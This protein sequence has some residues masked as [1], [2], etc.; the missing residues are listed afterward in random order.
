MNPQRPRIAA[1]ITCALTALVATPAHPATRTVAIT[2]QLIP[3][4]PGG[5][6][7]KDFDRPDLLAINNSGHVAFYATYTL[8]I[9][10]DV[11]SIWAGHPDDLSLLGYVAGDAPDTPSLTFFDQF[12]DL[13]L[14]N[15]GH[16]AYRASLFGSSVT[17]DDDLGI[18]SN[19]A[20]GPTQLIA[21]KG[22]TA[23]GSFS[24]PF[25][26][27]GTPF[28]NDAGQLAFKGTLD[29]G[30]TDDNEGI[31]LGDPADIDRI[32]LEGQPAPDLPAGGDYGNQLN[33]RAINPSG[34][35]TISNALQSGTGD[36]TIFNNA[37]QWAG[38]PDELMLFL[39]A[40]TPAPDIPG[41]LNFENTSG[42]A[43]INA[44]GHIAFR[45]GIECFC[46]D[47]QAIWVGPPEDLKVAARIA[48]PA[49]DAPLGARFEFFNSLPLLASNGHLAF[50]ATLEEGRGGVTAADDTVL[51]LGPP[52]DL[53]IAARKGDQA[54]GAPPGTNFDSFFETAIN[55]NG[56]AVIMNRVLGANQGIYLAD[57]H[58]VIPVALS[59]GTLASQ[60]IDNIE[61]RD[62]FTFSGDA[63]GKPRVINDRGQVVFYADFTSGDSGVFLFTPDLHYRNDSSGQWDDHN[64]WTVGIQPSDIHNV[65]IDTDVPLTVHGPTETTTLN[66]LTIGGGT[67]NATL[68]LQGSAIYTPTNVQ[69]TSNGTLT[70]N[71]FID[72][73]VNNDGTVLLDG[74]LA[75]DGNLNNNATL[76]GHGTLDA[77][78]LNNSTALLRVDAGQS[79]TITGFANTN[80]GRINLLGGTLAFTQN[81]INRDP[82]GL[83]TGTGHIHT[84]TGLT[85]RNDI[86]LSGPSTIA[87]DVVNDPGALILSTGGG[88]LTFLDDVNNEGD[89]QTSPGSFTVFLGTYAGRGKLLGAGTVNMQGDFTPGT[90]PGITEIAGDLVFGPFATFKAETLATNTAP[91]AG[92]DHDQIN[93]ANQLTLNG[94]LDVTAL[95][96]TGP[97]E[98]TTLGNEYVVIIYG[99][100]TPD[101]FFHTITGTLIDTGFA[102]APL[103]D[104]ATN[105]FI[106][107]ASVPGDLNFDNK[108]SVADLSTF[109]L[110]FNTTPGLYVEATNENSWELGDFNTDGAITVS[111]LSLLA[112]NFGFDA[113]AT[114]D[115]I[116][117]IGLSL[118]EIA[119]IA[120]I[121]PAAIPEPATV[122]TAVIC[123][124]GLATRR[125]R[126]CVTYKNI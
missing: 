112:L 119:A 31:W 67:A 26:F 122:L 28:L 94:T 115:P 109:A 92:I 118:V 88:P 48:H 25:E 18:W 89:I 90:S 14:N 113:T 41:D 91:V 84:A 53:K 22:D 12:L 20:G 49:P 43:T 111:D 95:P 107:R 116:P 105:Q 121:D 30:S 70:G 64:N 125:P 10:V 60:T 1:A 93:I 86:A 24:D 27:L 66:S 72:R 102:L 29:T 126:H 19:A 57:Q 39:R 69:I 123:T 42:S 106:L 79:I 13:N 85:N 9:G 82:S 78:L 37:A 15:A 5:A 74:N 35:I 114:L 59:G 6:V 124:G 54:P 80:T 108:V 55:A 75:I 61:L 104:K 73:G 96:D 2:G 76:T 110:N 120:G 58:Q 63:D 103:L 50:L 99:T 17:P 47:D 83:I 36:V 87:G 100:R 11:Q 101:S 8:T 77:K 62:V 56:Q 98:S 21:R 81:L 68:A 3:D 65:T 32:A 7:F 33:L 23:P 44:T 97:I 38:H 34:L 4:G 16:V 71:G 117:S 51:Y 45:H 40:R 46:D 52:D